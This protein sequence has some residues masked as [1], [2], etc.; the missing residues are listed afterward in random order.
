MGR[1][2]RRRSRC[3]VEMDAHHRVGAQQPGPLS[4]F[5]QRHL[6][7]LHHRRRLGPCPAA[8][9]VTD[10][11]EQIAEQVGAQN[12]FAMHQAQDVVDRPAFEAGCG[13]SEAPRY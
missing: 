5:R 12:R 9:Q 10:A 3:R 11:G 13:A 4:Q 8:H 1:L 6:P 2:Q 7:G